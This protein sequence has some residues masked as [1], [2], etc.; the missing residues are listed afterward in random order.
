MRPPLLW[1]AP[2]CSACS[3]TPPTATSNRCAVCRCIYEFC[4]LAIPGQCTARSLMLYESCHQNMHLRPPQQVSVCQEF[5]QFC[6]LTAPGQCTAES[7]MLCESCHQKYHVSYGHLKQM[8]SAPLQ[9]FVSATWLSLGDGLLRG[10]CSGRH[11]TVSLL[12]ALPI[13]VCC[14]LAMGTCLAGTLWCAL[15]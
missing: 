9:M 15:I 7:L 5:Y 12:A 6:S 11:S 2:S 1:R 13:V 10:R 14:A 3:A 4:S 8:R